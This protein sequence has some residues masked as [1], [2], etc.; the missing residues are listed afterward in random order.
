MNDTF[1]ELVPCWKRSPSPVTNKAEDGRSFDLF[2][3]GSLEDE[4]LNVP[5]AMET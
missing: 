4:W 5:S 3:R 1:E 2:D